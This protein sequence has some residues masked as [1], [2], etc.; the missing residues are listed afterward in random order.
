MKR[1]YLYPMLPNFSDFDRF[2]DLDFPLVGR[3]SRYLE[4]FGEAAP[5]TDYFEDEQNFY[6]RAELPGVKKDDVDLEV[7]GDAISLTAE[8][9]VKEGNK[10]QT[11][12]YERNLRLPDG[13]DRE[14]LSAKFE[15]GILTITLPKAEES[16]PR[17]ISVS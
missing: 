13:V 2:F 10:E 4:G 1:T 3:P 17:R 6:V 8:R 14:G 11:Y 15:D 12:R 7:Q 5:A 16:R 9:K